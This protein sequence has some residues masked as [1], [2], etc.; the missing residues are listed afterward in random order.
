MAEEPSSKRIVKNL[1][2]VFH[3]VLLQRDSESVRFVRMERHIPNVS[4]ARDFV[5]V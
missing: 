3:V 5:K 4:P 1:D 2:R